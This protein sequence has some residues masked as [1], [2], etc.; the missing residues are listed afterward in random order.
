MAVLGFG[1]MPPALANGAID[2]AFMSEPFVARSVQQGIAVRW[3]EAVEIYPQHQL[4]VLLYSTDFPR[5]EPEAAVRFIVA[6]L[7]GAREYMT[8]M[9]GSGDKN[10]MYRILAEYTPIKDLGIYPQMVL[11]AIH[12]DGAIN[13]DSLEADQALWV[14][15]GHVPQP[16]DL[17]RVIDLQYLQ[18]ALRRLDG[19]P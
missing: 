2:V 7:R 1:D 13:R 17:D 10:A 11:T 12:P 3:K 14:A 15:Q 8:V 16:A 18:E 6:Y 9:R 4:S 5:R 19:T